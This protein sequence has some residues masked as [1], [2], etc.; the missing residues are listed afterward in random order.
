MEAIDDRLLQEAARWHARLNA[1]D[2]TD[3]EHAEFESWRATSPLHAA[4]AARADRVTSSLNR[5]MADARMQALIDRASMP[6]PKSDVVKARRVR[7]AVPAALAAGLAVA[8][9]GVSLSVQSMRSATNAVVYQT[10]SERRTIT[11]EEG[12]VLLLDIGTQLSVRMS[13]E[14]REVEL[15]EGRASFDV[16]H[17]V[18][19]PFSVAAA[20]ARTTALGTKFQVQR[21]DGRVLVTLE[22]GS[23]LVDGTSSTANWR[24]LLAPG[25]QLTLD[26]ATAHID[27]RAVDLRGATSWMRGRHIFRGTPLAEAIVEVN[28]Y[29]TRKVRI[30][31]SSLAELPVSGSFIAGDTALI[32]DA[33]SG[34]LPIRV[35]A[36]S[37]DEIILFRRYE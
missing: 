12:S 26:I 6:V 24:E 22:A 34:V 35:V 27:K 13:A 32:V 28:R 1:S 11:L 23:V 16:A 8:V 25:E 14:R 17:D 2:C 9:V 7:W 20:D 30:G 36:G 3:Q 37:S 19:R 15:L 5:L 31:D 33:L 10:Q 18:R 4:A 21:D 29:A